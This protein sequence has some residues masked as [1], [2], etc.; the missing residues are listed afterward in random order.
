MYLLALITITLLVY[1]Y[2][3]YQSAGRYYESS[4]VLGP[5]SD[6]LVASTYTII[7]VSVLWMAFNLKSLVL[8]VV[9]LFVVVLVK[10]FLPQFF[11]TYYVQN[12]YDAGAHVGRGL[13][14][15]VTGYS[16]PK[17]DWYFDIQPGF[18]WWTA[19]FFNLVP[20]SVPGTSSWI[21]EFLIKWFNLIIIAIYIPIIF[22]L[23]R[24]LRLSMTEALAAVAVFLI[25]V[26]YGRLHYAAQTFS[27]ALYWLLVLV[28][29]KY[30]SHKRSRDLLPIP[31]ILTA[32]IYLHQGTFLFAVVALLSALITFITQIDV[33]KKASVV[34]SLTL[35]API[36]IALSL[37]FLYMIH[38]NFWFSTIL[39]QI[40]KKYV[41]PALD[42]SNF[43]KILM[44]IIYKPNEIWMYNIIAKAVFFITSLLLIATTN[45]KSDNIVERFIA[46]TTVMTVL[47][48]GFV[49]FSLGGTAFVERVYDALAPFLT[50]TL[51]RKLTG[52]KRFIAF[53][54]AVVAS[55][56]Y[57]TGWNFQSVAYSEWDAWKF[58]TAHTY[59]VA[60]IYARGICIKTLNNVALDHIDERRCVYVVTRYM[61]I[62]SCY[63]RFGTCEIVEELRLALERKCTIVYESPTSALYRC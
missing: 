47:F 13:Y 29:I 16:D 38:T 55:L 25:V 31:V 11:D 7:V 40:L 56:I 60:G 10:Y 4:D 57:F 46:L 14:V 52:G 24:E 44:G 49:G 15:Y 8:A 58:I 54:I 33:M 21:V 3:L 37:W 45:L 36:V 35:L 9:L 23:F 51:Y 48:I 19:I 17:I 18:F 12:F 5:L 63:Y 59:N 6:I 20:G 39:E 22:S 41:I 61:A 34:K 26:Y 53:V 2:L 43:F 42:I 50:Y 30:L 1:S 27:W 28:V 62:E 32:L